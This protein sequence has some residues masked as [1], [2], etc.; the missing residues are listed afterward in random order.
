MDSITIK[1]EAQKSPKPKK[2]ISN[3]FDNI[4]DLGENLSSQDIEV[5]LETLKLAM[6]EAKRKETEIRIKEEEAIREKKRILEEKKRQIIARREAKR[7]EEENRS[8]AEKVTCMD[9]PLDWSNTY[10]NDD[11]ADI[12]I[13]NIPDGLAYCL[14]NLGRVDIEY[15]SAI[16]DTDC[17]DVILSLGSSIYQNPLTWDECF[18]KGFET[19]DEYLSGNLMQKLE[20]AKEANEKYY[21]YFERNVNALKSL[22]G[23]SVNANDI[24]ITLGSPWV[25]TKII[26]DF[27]F[28]L[29]GDPRLDQSLVYSEKYRVKHDEL[30]GIWEIPEKTRFRKTRQHGRY[31]DVNYSVWGT[32]RMDMLYL[33]ENTLNMRTISIKDTRKDSSGKVTNIFNKEETLKI[34]QKQEEMVN[35]FKSW[36][37]QDKGRKARLQA[38]YMSR[39]GSIRKRSFDGSYLT[40]PNMNPEIK[41]FPHQKNAVARMLFSPNTLL[42][43]DVGAGKTYAMIAAG[44]EM[45]RLGKSDKNLYVVP[46][47]ILPQWRDAFYKCYPNINLFVVDSHNFS[48]KKR[49]KTLEAIKNE[50]FD[51]I[52]MA[53]SCFDMLCLSRKYY[54]DTYNKRLTMLEKARDKYNSSKIE[55]KCKVI[56]DAI[57][58]LRDNYDS[59]KIE[60]SVPFD[61]LGINTLFVDE[62]HNYKNVPIETRIIGVLGCGG[63]GSDKCRDMLDKVHCVQ[64]QN[65]G[66]GVVFATGTPITN[67]I[68]DIYVMQRYLQSGE[69][70][71]LGLS[72]FD[73]WAGMFG[74]KTS[75]FEIDVDTNNFHL[76]TRFAHFRNLPELASILSSIADFYHVEKDESLPIFDGY[77]DTKLDGNEDFKEYLANISCRADDVRQK[78]VSRQEDNLLKITTDGRK[79]ALD[80]RL[81]DMAY[82]LDT[83]SKV[84]MCAENIYNVYHETEEAK[85]VQLVFCDSSTPK[86]GFNLYDELR[87]LLMKMG[88]P[89][90]EVWFIHDA[91]T[92]EKKKHLFE[93]AREGKIRVMLGST[94]KMGLGV[95]VQERLVA[96][97]HLDVPWRPADMVQREGRILRRGNTSKSVKIFRYI[98]EGSFD[99]YSWQLLET[100]QKFISQLLNGSITKRE[101]T[102]VDETVL[103]YAEV[104]AL[105]IGNPL[106]KQ[107]VEVSNELDKY[108]ILEREATSERQRM[109][110]ELE[111]IPEKIKSIKNKISKAK[112]DKA[113]VEQ[114][115]YEYNSKERLSVRQ[116]IARAIKLNENCPVEKR[117]LEYG[118]FSVIIPAYMKPKK[119]KV[120]HR[121]GESTEKILP[122]VYVRR[123]GNYF[124]E[125]ES[126]SGI[127]KRLDNLI[128]GLGEKIESLEVNIERLQARVAFINNE[129]KKESPYSEIIKKLEIEL[130]YIDT[131][132]GVKTNDVA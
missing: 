84:M 129:L 130:D 32:N 82:G 94:F 19:A 3:F 115:P 55:R 57:D 1:V 131:N 107:R 77:T 37:W 30:T 28:H 116:E 22:I 8:H 87:F 14:D 68:T 15:I 69:L 18:Y 45:K 23:D 123:A 72:S 47:N 17:K 110:N 83:D 118:G 25:P 103:S 114:N 51:A 5:A 43:H 16:C 58:K 61:S 81:V 96:L 66:R 74:E 88:I 124:M 86:M 80:M 98:T 10:E 120:E 46:N 113:Y 65:G 111:E 125:I 38:S 99:A 39:Y 89:K 109:Q 90:N 4:K 6:Q 33:L 78:R 44:M 67:S 27:I 108:K 60:R 50:D 71:F 13:D 79:A 122:Y 128:E 49:E 105:A 2:I 106:I 132:L 119:V 29:V 53:Y 31:E 48:S 54:F 92:E 75:E 41:L 63:S 126:E 40:F 85:G 12:R 127:T 62:A 34:L 36:V 91:D 97:H 100:K 101:S 102:D 56:R 52:L 59:S 112:M 9:L 93:M 7:E 70:E 20:V 73:A 26:D 35:E 117:V 21:G 42:A 121:D 104:K 95:N 76:A 24:Y 11:R 64:R